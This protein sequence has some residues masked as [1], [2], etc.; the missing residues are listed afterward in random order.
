MKIITSLF[1]TIC[2]GPVLVLAQSNLK[3]GDN[4]DSLRTYQLNEVVVSNETMDGISNKGKANTTNNVDDF[5]KKLSGVDVINRGAYAA[6]PVYRGM[7]GDRAPVT[8][9]NMKIFGACTDK[10]DPVSSYV[11][12]NNLK[13]IAV[14]K[15]ASSYEAMNSTAG[16]I[17]FKTKSP[18]FNAQRV[19]QG[20][21]GGGIKS[22]NSEYNGQFSTAYSKKSMAFR[23][24]GT[25]RKSVV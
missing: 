9:N 4:P 6:E 12:T 13:S 24:N 21:L 25:Y 3:M 11:S 5:L 7:S 18:V 15:D 10:M 8:I 2:M 1:F 17:A 19:W 14:V 22:V 16:V 20:Q 23:A